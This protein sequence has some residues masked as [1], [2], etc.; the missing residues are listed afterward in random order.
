[1]YTNTDAITNKLPEIQALIE[2]HKPDLIGISEEPKNLKY[3]LTKAQLNLKNYEL[4]PNENCFNEDGRGMCIYCHTSTLAVL[5]KPKYLVL[6]LCS[7]KSGTPREQPISDVSIAV[8]TIQKTKMSNS[9]TASKT[10]IKV[11]KM[12]TSSS[13]GILTSQK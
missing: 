2:V 13:W 4:L 7:L 10:T 5:R 9:S 12:K 8:Q 1:M 3:P 6:N 11:H